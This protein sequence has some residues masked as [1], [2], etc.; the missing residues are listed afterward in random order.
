MTVLRKV[1]IV[2]AIA[3]ALS[4]PISASAQ[5][6]AQPAG[7]TAVAGA[8]WIVPLMAIS[9]LALAASGKPSERRVV[10]FRK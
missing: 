5:G 1:V 8:T 6:A 7:T 4:S 3:A 10:S 9:M 2:A